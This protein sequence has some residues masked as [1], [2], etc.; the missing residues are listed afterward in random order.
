MLVLWLAMMEQLTTR[1]LMVETAPGVYR[2]GLEMAQIR[3]A[4]LGTLRF[5]FEPVDASIAVPP[6]VPLEVVRRAGYVIAFPHLLGL[7]GGFDGSVRDFATAIAPTAK[8]PLEPSESPAWAASFDDPLFA[9]TPAACHGV[10]DLVPTPVGPSG[11]KATAVATCFRNERSSELG[12]FR[13]FQMF[14][15]VQIGSEPVVAA[16]IATGRAVVSEFFSALG[17]EDEWE[18]AVDPFFLGDGVASVKTADAP[19]H[20]LATALVPGQPRVAISSVNYHQEHFASA[21]D[22]S[23]DAGTTVSACLGIGIERL[24][25]ALFG[26]YGLDPASWP[27][28]VLTAIG[29]AAQA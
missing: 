3:R 11:F 13:S 16:F 12:R 10:Y 26:R 5:L 22:L 1:G 7:V 14:E 29:L 27:P 15:C 6:V 18:A 28:S 23:S 17:I 4:L 9:M 8:A 24:T 25:L 2:D 21:F 20:E 19:K